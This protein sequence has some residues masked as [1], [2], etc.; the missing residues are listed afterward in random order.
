VNGILVFNAGSSS[1]KCSIF[2]LADPAGAGAA[3][4]GPE[5]YCHVEVE[6][7]GGQS[8]LRTARKGAA[9][10]EERPAD[11]PDHARAV[12]VIMEWTQREAPT[13]EVV[14]AGHRVVHGGDRFSAPVRLD[15]ATVSALEELV[16]LAPLHQ[17]HGLVP[18]RRLAKLRPELPQVACFDTAFHR[19]Q[20]EVAATFAIPAELTKAGIRRYGFHGLSYEYIVKVFP[21]L[22]EGAAGERMVVAHLGNGAS[23][24]AIERGRSIATT[25]GFTPLDGLPM[26]TRSGSIDPGVILHLLSE[27]KMDAAAVSDL[28]Y[29]RSG[30]LGVSGVSHDMRDLL[31]SDSPRAA[32]AIDLFVYRIG[33]E[34]GSLAAALGGLDA[35]VFT[36]GIG[37]GSSEIRA[38]V[39]ALSR[40]LGLELDEPANARGDRRISTPGSRVSVWAIP[41]DEE[42]MIAEHTQALLGSSAR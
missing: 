18:I 8:R 4:A 10:P 9:Q 26:G 13:V 36:G 21:R 31:R 5:L 41:T 19:T 37:E 12:A 14:A 22:T 3:K 39:S 33:R 24:C 29:H 7:I 34:L 2:T 6:G 38:R 27:R 42:L 32:A 1:I 28:L 17:P 25:M 20:P 40:W 23:M 15:A 35:L 16:P 30:L 11:A